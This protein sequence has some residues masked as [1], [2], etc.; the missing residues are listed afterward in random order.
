MPPPLVIPTVG[1]C[2]A[3]LRNGWLTYVFDAYD[4]EGVPRTEANRKL[5]KKTFLSDKCD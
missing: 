3:T 1:L 4:I 5:I 2:V